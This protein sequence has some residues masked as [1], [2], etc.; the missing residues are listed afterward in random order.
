MLEG[1]DKIDSQ[2]SIEERK[3]RLVLACMADRLAWVQACE[4]APAPPLAKAGRILQMIEPFVGLLPGK[5][6]R[7]IRNA[8][9]AGSLL[10]TVGKYLLKNLTGGADQ[11]AQT[12]SD[13]NGTAAKP[14]K[15]RRRSAT[16][17]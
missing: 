5:I 3:Q 17:K 12:E 16:G 9:F 13:S 2:L 8:H 14:D 7:W 11:S 6:G 15:P 4:P 10:P 1:T